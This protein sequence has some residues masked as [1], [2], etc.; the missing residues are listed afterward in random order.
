VEI[1]AGARANIKVTG[2]VQ[3]EVGGQKHTVGPEGNQQLMQIING[4]VPHNVAM[5]IGLVHGRLTHD[6]KNSEFRIGNRYETS[7]SPGGKLSLRIYVGGPHQFALSGE[8]Q[9]EIEVE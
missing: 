9:V 3:I 7:G 6:R 4:Q 8:Y 1:P 5:P 2:N